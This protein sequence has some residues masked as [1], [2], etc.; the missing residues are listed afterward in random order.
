MNINNITVWFI[1]PMSDGFLN[2]IPRIVI[3]IGCIMILFVMF[4]L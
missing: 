4:K 1:S 3:L 2:P